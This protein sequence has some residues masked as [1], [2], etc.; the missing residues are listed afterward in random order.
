MHFCVTELPDSDLQK[1][2]SLGIDRYNES[3]SA[4]ILIEALKLK[5]L[6]GYEMKKVVDEDHIEIIP[7]VSWELLSKIE[8]FV[9]TYQNGVQEYLSVDRIVTLV[10]AYL[11]ALVNIPLKN[12][13][14]DKLGEFVTSMIHR[15]LEDL[16]SGESS[17]NDEKEEEKEPFFGNE[18][19]PDSS[20]KDDDPIETEVPLSLKKFVIKRM[21]FTFSAFPELVD[22]SV[23][24]NA[25]LK[26]LT[27]LPISSE[28][29]EGNKLIEKI[30]H[31]MIE[32]LYK[33]RNTYKLQ[34]YVDDGSLKFEIL[35]DHNIVQEKIGYSPEEITTA[36][37]IVS[38]QINIAKENFEMALEV[39]NSNTHARY[40]LSGL[41]LKYHRTENHASV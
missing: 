37:T 38:L 12:E 41:H 39:D 11:Q 34:V 33:K 14:I 40:R 26:L 36:L 25:E 24:S 10:H 17:R 1:I 7:I 28:T 4:K 29:E 2:M 5:G 23:L 8:K 35:I 16:S 9:I 18:D 27:L 13:F 31:A 20:D 6:S 32:F 15:Q 19:E 30:R 3:E 21:D 22:L